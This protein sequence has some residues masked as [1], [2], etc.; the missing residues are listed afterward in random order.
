MIPDRYVLRTVCWLTMVSMLIVSPA[1]AVT[2]G[3]KANAGKTAS[4]KASADRI[5][6]VAAGAR[7][8]QTYCSLCHSI[9]PEGEHG[10][11]GP[12]WYGLIGKLPRS[13]NVLV[14][15]IGIQTITADDEY[16]ETSISQPN[17]HLAIRETDP[18]KGN[19]YA[20]SMPPYPHL[21]P[22]ERR[23]LI[24]FMKTLNTPDN[25]GPEQV[26]E[27]KEALP[28]LPI[29]RFEVVVK[30][31]PLVY[32]VAMADVSTRALCVGLPGGFN[33]IFDPSTFSVKRAWIGGFVNLK[34][35]RT[36]RGDGY[37]QYGTNSRDLGFEECLLPLGE[38]G[39]INQ[40]F[41]DYLH[42]AAW[43]IEKSKVEMKATTAFVDRQPPD[44]AQFEGYQFDQ[45]QAPTFLFRINGVE[46]AQ[47]VVF[48]SERVMH[49]YFATAGATGPLRFRIL[50]DKILGVKTSAGTWVGDTLV[51]PAT[52]AAQFTITLTLDPTRVR[53][54]LVS[55][56]EVSE[57]G[58]YHFKQQLAEQLK[59][60]GLDQ[61]TNF[62]LNAEATSSGEKDGGA[63]GPQAAVDGSVDTY[64]DE[65]DD[66]EKYELNLTLAKPQPISVATLLG[67]NHHDYAPKDFELIIDGKTI[68]TVANA[69]YDSNLLVIEFP[70]TECRTLQLKVSSSYGYSPAVRELGLYDMQETPTPKSP[71]FVKDWTVL[72]LADAAEQTSQRTT[73]ESVNRGMIAF[74]KTGC[75]KCHPIGGQGAHTGPD[76]TN[77][78]SKY[79]GSKLLQQIIEPS[80][81]MNKDF[82]T[83]QILTHDGRVVTGLIVGE[84][85]ET[86]SIVP[87]PELP[88]T[89]V[90]ISMQDIESKSSAA[91]S[92]MPTGMI[93]TLT[94]EEILDLLTYLEAGGIAAGK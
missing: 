2:A 74:L 76:L 58:R 24:A 38:S 84:D 78:V 30:D 37:N 80:S 94:K 28:D 17:L 29:E 14:Q 6:L 62:A 93:S 53:P 82:L 88:E 42:N 49:Y 54:L 4:D 26:W 12:A 11:A 46:Y 20:P 32:R 39:P 72:E 77:V 83:W 19:A 7:L 79:Q 61:R 55:P 35:E 57:A 13:R 92:S 91:V 34:A 66:Q 67:W 10:L 33:Y 16:I 44:G 56:Y 86:L 90:R 71:S 64:W 23:S 60:L 21:T 70:R 22:Q 68:K 18:E 81:E 25:R 73:P 50:R 41:K 8:Y 40:D 65:T 85:E 63:I 5:D 51:I 36:G 59:T 9:E 89:I 75:I 15:P 87:N 1:P 45:G 3:D 69:Q 27:V 47:R 48:E 43:R 31:R 52:Q